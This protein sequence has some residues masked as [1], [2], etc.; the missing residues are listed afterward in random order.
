MQRQVV[1]QVT[2]RCISYPNV[3]RSFNPEH[4]LLAV[5]GYYITKHTKII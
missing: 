5:D 4:S 3:R 1:Y 2:C